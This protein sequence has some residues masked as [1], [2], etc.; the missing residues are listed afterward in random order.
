MALVTFLFN[1]ILNPRWRP[2]RRTW[3]ALCTHTEHV[4]ERRQ[5]IHVHAAQTAGNGVPL[6]IPY[7]YISPST[8]PPKT[9]MK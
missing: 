8:K 5:S 9:I 6:S 3:I 7:K 1:I 2:M 4:R